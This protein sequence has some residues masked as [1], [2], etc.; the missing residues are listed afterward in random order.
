MIAQKRN[1]IFMN[2]IYLHLT[3]NKRRIF[4]LTFSLVLFLFSMP[5]LQATHVVGSD[6]SYTCTGTPGVYNVTFKLYKDCQG[7]QLCANCPTSLSPACGIQISIFGAASPAGSGMPAS[8]CTGVS[9]GSQN[10]TVVTSVSGFDVV[11][12]CAAAKSICSNCGSRTPGTFVPGIEVYTFDGLINLSAIPA[13]CCFVSIGWNT[14]C[15]NN[16]ITTLANPGSLNFYTEAII[17]RCA[18]PCNSSPTFTNDP[19]A[20]T[21]AGQD[22]TYN[23]GAIDPDGDSL[24]YAFGQALVGP[25]SAAPYVS[26]YSPLV[27]L[28]YLGAPIQSPPAIPPIGINIDA[29]TGDIRFRP[30]G[31]FVANLIIEV[32]Q[33]KTIGGVPTLMG[34]TRRDIQFYSQF[35]PANNPP[36]FRTYD[37]SSVLTSPQPNFAYSVC[38]GQQLCFTVSAWD[39]TA[40]TDT[41]DMTWNAPSTLVGN[42]ATFVKSYIVANRNSLGPKFDSMKFCWTPTANMAS[43]LPY[44]MVVTAKDRACPIPARTT[45]SFSILVRKIPVAIINKVNKNCGFYDFSYTLQ[46]GVPLN[47]SYTQF[48]V[49]TGPNSNSYTIYNN[50]SVTNHQFLVG[51]WHRVKLRLTTTSPPTPNGCPNDNIID[52]VYINPPVDVAVRDTFNCFGTPVAIQA[53]GKNGTPFGLSYRYTFYSLPSN[54]IIRAFGIDSNCTINP[55]ISGTTSTYKAVIQDLNGCR[56]SVN[57]SVF[58]RNLPLKELPSSVRFCFSSRDTLDAGNSLGS[59]NFWRWSKSPVSPVLSD[60]V[61]QKILPQDSGRYV[62]RKMDLFG[63]NRFDTSMVYV[64]AQV[65][66]SAGPNRTICAGDP[67]INIVASGT[68]ASIDSFQWRQVPITNPNLVLSTSSALSVSPLVNTTYQ[69]TG[70]ITYGGITC[71]YVDSMDVVVKQKPVITR[72][73]DYSL[74][75]NTAVVLLPAITSTNKPGQITSV[76]TYP[77]NPLAISGNQVIINNLTNLPPAPPTSARGN[78]INLTVTDIDGCR[79]YDSLVISIFPV[80]IIN[81]GP[82][83]TWCDFATT[84]NINPGSQAYTPNGGALATNEQWVGRGISRPNLSVNYYVF[85]PQASD[86]NVL[87][88]TNVITYRFTATF[89]LNNAVVFVPAVAGYN[90]PSPTGGCVASDTVLFRV[91]KTPKLETGIAPPLCKSGSA[92]DLDAH[93]LGRSTNSTN[94]LSS[95]WYI[96]APDQLYKSAITGGRSFNPSSAVIEKYT[97][98]YTLVYADTSTTCRVADTTTIQVNENPVVDIDYLSL[99]DSAVCKTRGNVLFFMNPNNIPSSDANMSSFPALPSG[100]FDVTAGKFNI[101]S[102]PAGM[103]NIKYYYKDPGTGCDNRDSVNIRL[104]DAPIIDI[105]DDGTVCSYGAVFSVGFKTVPS[106]PYTWSWSTPDGNGSILDNGITG[107]AYTATAADIARGSITF[108]ATTVDLTTDPDV[109]A[110]VRDSATFI[111]KPKPDA[112]FSIAPDRACVDDRYGVELNSVYTATASSVA[113]STYKWFMDQSDYNTTPMNAAPYDQLVHNQKF[114]QSGNHIIHLFVEANGCTDTAFAPVYAWP[115]PIAK[116]VSNPQSTTIAKPYF[117]FFNQSTI[118]DNS[119]LTYIWTF[120]PLVPGGANRKDYTSDPK[121][122][123]FTAD[124]GDVPVWLT[125]I[126]EHGCYDSTS[127]PIRIEPDITVFIPNVFRPVNSDDKGGAHE[128]VNRVFRVSA[129]GFE[130]IEIYV[131]NRWGQMVYKS[132]M[133]NVTFDDKEGWNGRDF[134]TGKDCQQDAYIYQI[135]ATSFNGKKYNYSGSLTLLR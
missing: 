9:F 41:T 78:T 4:A 44:Y 47:N 25:G 19:V 87:P 132:F 79:I 2:A 67:N 125:V 22:F 109:C 26:P 82:S 122:I 135:N 113:G 84:F 120:P 39:N 55:A 65:P 32:R 85:N 24:S 49:E 75:R 31:N 116:F 108:K 10:L 104:Q 107:I 21:C 66:V 86:V 71:S 59:V 106:S 12:L 92:V 54:N 35:C 96:G 58:T 69:V 33:W 13:S 72:P 17:N 48:Q 90:A 15:R 61:S 63:C 97:K 126:S 105:T 117:D 7:V 118:A 40:G 20:V 30:L 16:A 83:R 98:Q 73:S 110:A 43:N 95:Y 101:S 8:P 29:V 111:I 94:P 68:T 133:T 128:G 121:Q 89:P 88:D 130:T 81:A 134:N 114:T 34:I 112:T 123:Q 5:K 103:Y 127:N 14:C 1:I 3:Q 74:C 70:F 124:T 52:S 60:S 99:S 23:L 11:S 27:P 100:D 37:A 36:V 91:I 77:S 18:T 51:G 119:P 131:F 28:P 80:P 76:W 57:F 38:A 6:V 102:A 50:T 62:V 129:T 56:D 42:G 46:N 45:R 64:N 53:K 115:T 93:M